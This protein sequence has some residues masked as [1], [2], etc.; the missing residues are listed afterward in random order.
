MKNSLLKVQIEGKVALLLLV[1]H[2][3]LQKLTQYCLN[4]KLGLHDSICFVL[5][6]I[7]RITLGVCRIIHHNLSLCSE[8]YIAGITLMLLIMLYWQNYAKELTFCLLAL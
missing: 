1:L 5:L 7:L 8:Q 3:L 4:L 6:F 2:S